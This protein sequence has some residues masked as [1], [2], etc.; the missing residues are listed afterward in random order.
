MSQNTEYK[1]KW[2]KENY[3]RIPVSV[4][5]GEK[6]K[7]TEHYKRK[8]YKSMNDYINA[9]IK[10]D[11]NGGVLNRKTKRIVRQFTLQLKELY[12]NETQK[13]TRENRAR[14]SIFLRRAEGHVSPA[15]SAY[16]DLLRSA[17]GAGP[18]S[19]P[20]ASS[21]QAKW[22]HRGNAGRNQRAVSAFPYASTFRQA[23]D[24]QR[25]VRPVTARWESATVR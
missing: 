12:E 14:V 3:D 21:F 6:E 20:K 22:T 1:N 9:L 18:L 17:Q 5:K 23:T 10:Q 19:T 24:A 15:R 13:D 25:D 4:I 16:Q 7:I 8:G 11:M 2:A